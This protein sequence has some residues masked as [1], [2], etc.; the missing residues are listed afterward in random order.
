ME[1][2]S[3]GSTR[4]LTE[5]PL[6]LSGV[7]PTP[8]QNPFIAQSCTTPTMSESE[9]K[10]EAQERKKK[11]KTLE[12]KLECM[13]YQKFQNDPTA[14]YCELLC[15]AAAS[16]STNLST[17]A[18]ATHTSHPAADATA[19]CI[20]SFYSRCNSPFNSRC[21]SLFSNRCSSPSNSKYSQLY[22]Q[23]HSNTVTH[24]CRTQQ[25]A[26]YHHQTRQLQPPTTASCSNAN[27]PTLSSLHR[28]IL[29]G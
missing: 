8:S 7:S 2:I 5:K 9:F 6:R 14:A 17:P 25:Q 24:Q 28:H 13:I 15:P 19:R 16:T 18:H 11:V 26:T 3:V 20:I 1:S 21:S 29:C 22:S 4:G 27:G 12:D 23:I 10:M